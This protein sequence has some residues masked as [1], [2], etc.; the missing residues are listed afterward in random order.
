MAA[1]VAPGALAGVRVLDLSRI[2][3]GPW[4]TQTLA[5]LGADVIKVERPGQGDDSRTWGPPFLPD[6][7]GQDTSDSAYYL[8]ANR[9][10]RSICCDLSTEQGQAL[11]RELALQSDVVVENFKVGDLKRY[12]LDAQSLA[13]LKPSLVICSVTGFGQTGPYADRA[14]YDYAIQGLGGLMSITGE[15][16]DLPGGGPQKVTCKV[17]ETEPV[18]KG[19]TAAN[20][21]KPAILDNGVKVMVPPFIAQDEM[22]IVNTESMEYSER[23]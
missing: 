10:K 22:I 4:C 7:Q 6:N 8:C 1:S 3:A 19:Q 15:R 14:G 2:L 21:F 12:G 13:Q 16:D 11:V 20:S 23:A 9:N 5:D 18:V 17:V